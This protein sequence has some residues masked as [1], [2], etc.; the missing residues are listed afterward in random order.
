[1]GGTLYPA[2]P[3]PN[4]T[5]PI[6]TVYEPVNPHP[7]GQTVR[8]ALFNP[9]LV[10]QP[11]PAFITL[12]EHI[13][14]VNTVHTLSVQPLTIDLDDVQLTPVTQRPR[15][16]HPGCSTIKYNRPSNPDLSK[17][18]IHFCNYMGYY[19]DIIP[20]YYYY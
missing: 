5:P 8:L 10:Q 12:N 11:Q 9:D 17:R 14:E 16:T 18:R 7:I 13:L 1:M 3:Q 6:T 20:Y 4:D 19:L 15:K 2:D